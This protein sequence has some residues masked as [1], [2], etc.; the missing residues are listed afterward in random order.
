MRTQ[1]R[2]ASSPRKKVQH[3]GAPL[4]HPTHRAGGVPESRPN[5]GVEAFRLARG[6]SPGS[7]SLGTCR[8]SNPTIVTQKPQP[9]APSLL[10]AALALAFS[11]NFTLAPVQGRRR[12]VPSFSETGRRRRR[13]GA[14]SGQVLRSARCTGRARSP[15][16]TPG[17][18]DPIGPPS[19][20]VVLCH[21]LSTTG[22]KRNTVLF[23][24]LHLVASLT[25]SC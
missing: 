9:S 16:G 14:S 8:G 5:S 17:Q 20:K 4:Q 12:P 21:E 2:G 13:D 18:T 7:V 3:R 19:T 24:S 10:R 6:S 25:V 1:H 11:A 15:H 23:T 22:D